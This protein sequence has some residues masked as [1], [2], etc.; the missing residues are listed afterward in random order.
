MC[1]SGSVPMSVIFSLPSALVA[2]TGPY[3]GSTK[4]APRPGCG[5]LSTS[6]S[7]ASFCSFESTTA[8]LF[9]LV[10]GRHE[11][12]LGAVPAAV[13]QEAR[14]ADRRGP[15]VVDVLVVDQ[16]D[17]P[18]LLDVDDELRMLVRGDDRGHARLG[19]ELLRVDGHA[20]GRHDL[21]RL[22]R[23]AVHD[24]VLRR[25]VGAGD[26]VLVLVALV[27]RGLDRARLEADLDL[28]DADRASSCTGR[29]GRCWPSRPIVYT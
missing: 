18:G 15:E 17:L 23:R 25:P 5:I 29:S 3:F 12:A 22:E 9:G 13:V 24:R 11:V 21:E 27:L 16:Q 20:A 26:R 28:G 19:V 10:G 8:I 4:L 7:A 6:T 1:L 14:G 2:Q